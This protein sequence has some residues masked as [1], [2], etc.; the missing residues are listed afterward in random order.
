MFRNMLFNIVGAPL[1]LPL[2]F[3]YLVA[4]FVAVFRVIRSP[5]VSSV[6][7]EEIR[8]HARPPTP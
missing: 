1:L 7:Q 6:G 8:R 5:G 2:G 4:F 3:A